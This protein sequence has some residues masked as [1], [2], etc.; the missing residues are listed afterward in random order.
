VIAFLQPLALLGLLAAGIPTVL[1][2]LTRRLPPTVSFP[3]VRYLEETE[4]RQSRR[5]KLRHLLLLLLRTGLIASVVLAAAR[6]VARMAVGAAHAPTSLVLIV[7]NSLSAGAVVEGRPVADLLA[8]RARDV[9]SRVSQGD[10]L[11]LMLADGLPRAMSQAEAV[12]ALESLSPSPRRL[13]LGLAVR[14]AAGIAGAEPGLTPEIVVLSDLQRSALSGGDPVRVRV[15]A[16]TPG[17]VAENRSLDSAGAEPDVWSPEGRVVASVSG[18]RR[19]PAALSLSIGGQELTRAVA[20]PGDR[21]ILPARAGRHGWLAGRAA[22]DPDELRADDDWFLAVR[23]ADPAPATADPSAGR[24]VEQALTVL[25]EAGRV[26]RGGAVVIADHPAGRR[27]IVVPPSDPAAIGALNR[28]LAARGVLWQFGERVDGSWRMRGDVGPADGSTLGRRY[29]LVGS[30]AV[31]ARADD[32]P[33]LVRQQ[34]VVLLGSRL[35][36]GWTDLPLTAA[37]VPFLDLLVNRVAVGEA[38]ALNAHPGDMVQLPPTVDAVLTAQGTIPVEGDRRVSAP[39]EP[40]VYFLRGATGD[41]VGALAVNHDP[42]ESNLAEADQR[43][44]RAALGPEVQLLNQRGLEGELFGGAGRAD[45]S[46]I[47]LLAALLAAAAELAVA[48]LGARRERSGS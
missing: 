41:T 30:G 19:A 15:L 34:D 37:F 21:V 7:D 20:Y 14:T 39:R 23:V 4:R 28:A 13:D 10:R 46:G 31:L 9:V 29:R 11:R 2:L 16:W 25:T 6:P 45:L 44:L 3:A 33:W 40:G 47:F 8:A 1:H 26:G 42:R 35:E 43:A 27:S 32:D 18:S 36:D 5:L 48:S 22:L 38:E 24:Y 12:S 17:M